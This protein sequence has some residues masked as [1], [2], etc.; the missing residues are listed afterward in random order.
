MGSG[1]RTNYISA[2]SV[3]MPKLMPKNSIPDFGISTCFTTL[4]LIKIEMWSNDNEKG[5]SFIK[6]IQ[7]FKQTK[8]FYSSN[9]G[10]K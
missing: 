5:N 7:I 1:P 3:F 2:I 4:F 10:N 9:S 8:L 6:F